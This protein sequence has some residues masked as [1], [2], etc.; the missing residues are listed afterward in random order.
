MFGWLRRRTEELFGAPRSG[1]WPRVRREHLATQPACAACGRAKE[2]EVHHVVP[3]RDRPELELD[4]ADL[5]TLCGDP[6]HLV[7]GHLLSWKRSN[8]D[9]REDAARYR[10]KMLRYED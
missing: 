3:F 1:E 10:A 9:V 7:H 8:P 5:I 6:C 4:P 2:V